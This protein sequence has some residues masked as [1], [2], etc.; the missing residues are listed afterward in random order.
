MMK[1][2]DSVDVRKEVC[3]RPV[4][5][6]KIKMNKINPGEVL[7]VLADT[8]SQ[9][10]ILRIFG[11]ILK[12]EVVDSRSENDYVRILLRKTEGGR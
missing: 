8:N 4:L 2:V 1:I 7:E 10:D 6:V 3:S 11:E 9:K 12:H 5:D